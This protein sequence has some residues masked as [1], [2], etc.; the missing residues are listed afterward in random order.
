VIPAGV[1]LALAACGP[2]SKAA[3]DAL[4]PDAPCP[5]ECTTDGRAIIDCHGEQVEACPDTATCEVDS[6]TCVDGCMTAALQGRSV[7]CDY[8]ATSMD[9]FRHGDCFAAIVANT[10]PGSAHIAV[11][12]Q[13]QDLPVASFTKIPVGAGAALTYSAYDPVAGLAPGEVAVVFLGGGT[14]ATPLCPFASAVPTS[15][16]AGTG[17][18]SSFEIVTDVPVVAYQ[19]N[20]YG[21]GAAAVTGSSLLLP[22]SV[23]GTEYVAVNAFA[24]NPLTGGSPMRTSF[25]P[26]LNLV[27]SEDG[28]V[29]TITP[30]AA[31]VGGG[32]I[33]AGAAGQP[34]TINLAKGQHAQI[35]QT[36]ELTGSIVT[37]N[38]PIGFMAGQPCMSIPI[39]ANFCDHGEQM[40]PPVHAAGSRYVAAM[41]RPRAV[42]ETQTFWRAVGVVDGTQ[43]VYSTAVGGPATL[44][45]GQSVLFQTGT[46]F[47]VTS[48][49]SDHPFLLFA[50]MTS[51]SEVG[52][53]LGDPDFVLVVPPDQYLDRYVFFADPTYPET[54]LV[55]VRKRDTQGNFH[56]V[57]LDCAGVVTGWQ[58]VGTDFEL[59]R[60]D[61]STGNFQPVGG[62][63]TGRREITSDEPFGLWIWGWGATAT[64]H[65]VS[66]GYPGGMD[67]QPIN[68]VIL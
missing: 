28:T 24:D 9:V 39:G 19:I 60:V 37:S 2:T 8:Y 61:L 36:A 66:Y 50:Y 48:Q 52:S 47:V 31:I 1:L 46:P 44:A 7:G 65:N 26:S 17:L 10:W 59:A 53:G 41:Y 40:V 22:T 23:W 56:D 49:D 15:S 58:P 14:G 16:F 4:D 5:R 33:G 6:T 68:N 51:E 42:G 12:F 63:S 62:C 67:V 11:S 30:V 13:G 25:S 64:T 32:G 3:P 27:A 55:L 43:L 45:K 57:T 20:P 35:T 34:L 38:H 21:G 29:A 54:N 18:G